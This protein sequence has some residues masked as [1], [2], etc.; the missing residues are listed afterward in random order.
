M[1]L[2]QGLRGPWPSWMIEKGLKVNK[3][4]TKE[5]LI[6]EEIVDDKKK[7]TGRGRIY[8]PKLT[9]MKA[10]IRSENKCLID[11]LSKCLKIDPNQRLSAKEALNHPFITETIIAWL[12]FIE[13]IWKI[14]KYW[15]E[16][17]NKC[18]IWYKNLFRS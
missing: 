14:H 16:I 17:I 1:A 4:F 15:F 3:Y 8:S 9:N 7:K 5:M 6:Y 2:I 11:F 18:M 10:R 12:S 13:F